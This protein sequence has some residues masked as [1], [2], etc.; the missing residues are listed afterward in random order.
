MKVNLNSLSKRA[1]SLISNPKFALPNARG[2]LTFKV[3][4][5]G[6]KILTAEYA[7]D[8]EEMELLFSEV[9][10]TFSKNKSLKD[11]WQISY[12]EIENFLRDENHL[13][14]SP[15]AQEDL[16]DIYIKTKLSL[17]ADVLTSTHKEEFLGLKSSLELWEELSLVEK[18]KWSQAFLSTLSW[19][20]VFCER[21]ILTVSGVFP[22][23]KSSH[24]S[25]FVTQIFRGE[26]KV[27]P[28][29]LVAV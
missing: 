25:F 8:P 7:G 1:Q 26:G 27:L 17:M 12:R 9:L 13:P 18:N 21:D 3:S 23:L 2:P 24:L 14:F 5:A 15:E 16:E 11:L 4:T 20:L 10:A 29:K 19:E 22:G 28:M 6:D